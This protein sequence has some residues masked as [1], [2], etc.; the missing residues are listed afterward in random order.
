MCPYVEAHGAIQSLQLNA[1]S[2]FRW[3]ELVMRFIDGQWLLTAWLT[4]TSA[5]A[6]LLFGYDKW[7]AG[8]QGGRVA[9]STLCL[10]SAIGGWPGGLLGILIFRHKSSKKQFQVK[11][12]MALLVWA[13]LLWLA[14]RYES[15]LPTRQSG[16]A[17]STEGFWSRNAH[18]P[19]FA[20]DSVRR[21]SLLPCMEIPSKAAL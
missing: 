18:R 13:A 15:E 12:T 6:F 3:L 7:R 16:A 10:V 2:R 9:E 14:W 21:T 19:A 4:A 1:F 17:Q 8:G 11:F 20:R 5:L